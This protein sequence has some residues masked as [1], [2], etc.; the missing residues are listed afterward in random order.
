MTDFSRLQATMG[1]IGAG[2]E[3]WVG[4]ETNICNPP[5]VIKTPTNKSE[6]YP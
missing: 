2:D 4:P 5:G 3:K 6:E 1:K